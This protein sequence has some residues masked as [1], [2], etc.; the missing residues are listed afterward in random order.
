MLATATPTP[1]PTATPAPTP[2]SQLEP[3]PDGVARTVKVPILMYHYISVPPADA[4]IYRVDLSVPPTS[5]PPTW[6]ASRPKAIQLSASINCW[7]TS[8]RVRLY[9]RSLS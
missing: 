4:D 8:H 1:L 6:T 9:Q 5:L 2:T 3:T 7:H